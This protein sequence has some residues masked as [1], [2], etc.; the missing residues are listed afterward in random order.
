MEEQALIIQAQHGDT[1]ALAQLLQF[2]YPFVMKY[3]IKVTLD[4]HLA[5]DL[6]Q[7]TM[8]KCI[9]KIKL[10]NGSS[11][12][13]SWLITLATHLYI[14]G[15]RKRKR[16]RIWHEQELKLRQIKYQS[17]H[18]SDDWP[19]VLDA[20]GSISPEVRTPIVLKYYYGYTL[21]EIAQM[22]DIP[23]GTVKSRIH[24][25]VKLIRKQVTDDDE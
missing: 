21:E 23:L 8:L 3:L 9:N 25:G 12:F 11:K 4:P 19:V 6:A 5:E 7:E 22:M 20:L 16:E 18:H 10:Y 13:S 2:H 1:T 24:N 14:D 15:L 17:A